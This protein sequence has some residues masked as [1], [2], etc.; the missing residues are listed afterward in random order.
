MK[1]LI[2]LLLMPSLIFSEQN[3]A[4]IDSSYI[5]Q[6][7]SKYKKISDKLEKNTKEVTKKLRKEKDSLIK[8]LKK[9][10]TNQKNKKA[11][12]YDKKIKEVDSDLKNQAIQSY[13]TF[14]EDLKVATTKYVSKEN[15]IDMIIDIANLDQS[16]FLTF[17][18]YK[19][20]NNELIKIIDSQ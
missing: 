7:S 15:N 16:P 14:Y 2:I 1:Y 11:L 17:D 4:Y 18:S 10:D 20:I 13:N 12:E 5:I 3:I 19:N 8:E 9:L 6:T